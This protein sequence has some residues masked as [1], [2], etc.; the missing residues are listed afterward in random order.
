M[1][2]TCY[3]MGKYGTIAGGSCAQTDVPDRDVGVKRPEFPEGDNGAY[4]VVTPDVQ[5]IGAWHNNKDKGADA[6]NLFFSM[7]ADREIESGKN[8]RLKWGWWLL[9]PINC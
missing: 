4:A 7:L 3:G 6:L 8:L 2:V 9:F 5:A 1:A